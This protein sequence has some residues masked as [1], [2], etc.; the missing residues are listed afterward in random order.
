MSPADDNRLREL[1]GAPIGRL[2]WRYTLPAITGIIVMQLYNIVDRIFIGT[3]V[4]DDAIAGLAITFPVA[5]IATAFGI[6]VGSGAS[7]RISIA[8]GA[9]DPSRARLIAGNALLMLLINGSVYIAAFATFLD[10]I[11]DLFGATDATRPYARDMMLYILPGLLLTNLTFSFNGIM[12][13]SGFP[14]RAMVTMFVGAITNIALDPLFIYTFD[15]G[16]KG[17]AIATDIAMAA[18]CLFVM[19]HFARPHGQ[20]WL[21]RRSMRLQRHILASIFSIGAA[22]FI[23]NIASCLINILINHSLIRYGGSKAIASAS[24]F[25]TV[26][27]FACCMVIGIC[28]GMQPIVGYNFGARNF[29]RLR[30]AFTLSCIAATGV[31]T[32]GFAACLI[33]PRQLASLFLNDPALIE[34]TARTL[35]LAT[36]MFWLVGFQIVATTFFQSIG[37]VAKSIFLSLTR[38]VL[39]LIPLLLALPTEFGID[40]IWLSFPASDILAFAV[41]ATLIFLQFRSLRK[42]NGR[43]QTLSQQN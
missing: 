21:E 28:Q 43:S 39:F 3:A 38:Q 6:L 4:G 36:S 20:V 23:V 19:A 5:N 27:A 8:L 15:M 7:A 24:V 13:A 41:T 33:F 9:G 29:H 2:L 40:G 25:V 10:P 32:A 17:A 12:R 11:L 37:Q 30:R 18:S 16:I 22:P 34:S 26:T 14:R 42:I 35:S 1:A 31:C